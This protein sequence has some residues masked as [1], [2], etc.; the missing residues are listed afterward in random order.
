MEGGVEEWRVCILLHIKA[1][2]YLDLIHCEN[3][4]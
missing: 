2:S 3:Q 1:K 4:I